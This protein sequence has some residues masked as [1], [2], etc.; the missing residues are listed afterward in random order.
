MLKMYG[1]GHILLWIQYV[2]GNEA[3]GCE[4]D[5][6]FKRWCYVFSKCFLKAELLANTRALET[7]ERE[8]ESIEQFFS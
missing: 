3:P 1:L 8:D 7:H 6:L 4:P 2:W 5:L